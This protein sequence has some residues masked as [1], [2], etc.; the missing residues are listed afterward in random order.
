MTLPA[1]AAAVRGDDYQYA[2]GWHAACRALTEP[3]VESVSIE[4]AGG[5]S[6]DDVVLRRLDGQHEYIQ[7]KNSNYGNVVIDAD[8]LLT[9][10][11]KSGKAPLRHLYDTWKTLRGNGVRFKLITSR[12]IDARDPI[13]SLRDVNTGLLMPRLERATSGSNAGKARHT[14]T[15]ALGITQGE[16]LE[17]LSEMQFLTEGNEDSWRQRVKPL[18]RQAGLRDDDAA[19]KLGIDIVREWVKHGAGTRTP[20]DIR[21]EAAKSQLLA[22]DG[23]L[24]LAV[25][26]IDR[27]GTSRAPTLTLDWVDRFTGET[28]R[29]RRV[30]QNPGSWSTMNQ[31]LTAAEEKLAG[32][33]V[34]RLHV[35]GAMRLSLG[36]AVGAAFPQTRG[37]T[38]S[39]DQR[40][41]SWTTGRSGGAAEE[42]ARLVAPTE[43]LAGGAE[44][45]VAVVACLTLDATEDVRAH[46][47][48]AGLASTLV[49][50][51][52]AGQIGQYSVVDG[53]QASA[54][55]RS[56]RELLRAELR[57]VSPS[58]RCLHLFL[59]AP[60]G[61]ALFLGHDWNLLPRTVIY[62]HVGGAR[63]EPT[64][65][66]C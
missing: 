36:F 17:F 27:P 61:V 52:P 41:S 19:V 50:L 55:A 15:E 33:G 38:L 13:L 32:F 44:D 23:T 49:S 63:Y 62:E 47:I 7:V 9:A 48:A 54:W 2:V 39:I 40:G 59:A 29:S 57:R 1:R 60:L 10:V 56:A 22:Q 43:T 16:L 6:F 14:W 20:D 46:V 4:D 42:G 5:G 37:W 12:G 28:P 24:V 21:R 35:E 51:G 53:D 8:W 31:E 58:A 45:E 30:V 18:M 11:V 3:G 25:H 34:P 66:I 65:T 64:F 26:A